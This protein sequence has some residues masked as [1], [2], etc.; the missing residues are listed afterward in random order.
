MADGRLMDGRVAVVTGGGGGIA[1]A[2]ARRFAGEGAAYSCDR[3]AA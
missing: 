2:I 1:G 3:P